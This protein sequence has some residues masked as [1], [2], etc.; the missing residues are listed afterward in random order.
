MS[1]KLASNTSD[2][3]SAR[4]LG[5]VNETV[6]PGS[7]GVV[8]LAG[9]MSKLSLGSPYVEGDI[10]WLGS[11]PGTFT[12]V[13][14]TAPDHR[15]YLGVVERANNG[16]GIAYVKV[17]NGYELDEIHDVSI[18]SPLSG[19]TIRRNSNNTLWENVN[20]TYSTGNR[21]IQRYSYSVVSSSG[22]TTTTA[23]ASADRGF[24]L[25]RIG[26]TSLNPYGAGA[27]IVRFYVNGYVSGAGA[28]VASFAL[29]RKDT[30][31]I[32]PNSLLSTA[33]TT[34]STLLS[35]TLSQ[36]DFPSALTNVSLIS[37]RSGGTGGT[38]NL[39]TALIE[40]LYTIN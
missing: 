14:P 12:R 31:E 9:S 33:S 7:T 1:V 11:T 25:V 20:S 21:I 26:D 6:A 13:K 10:L 17:Q 3:T 29:V 37:W 15:V 24:M 5:F 28:P 32:I 40:L 39:R 18:V 30:N 27:P 2:S 22:E 35:A 16:N 36:A 38:A 23:T 34:S 4:T 8:T 19:Q